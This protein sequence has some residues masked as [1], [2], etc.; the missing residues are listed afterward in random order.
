M[1]VKK[2]EGIEKMNGDAD[3]FSNAHNKGICTSENQYIHTHYPFT[4]NNY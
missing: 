3:E 2:N 1:C 4:T